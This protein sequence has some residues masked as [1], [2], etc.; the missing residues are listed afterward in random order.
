MEC[1]RPGF[2]E[3]MF[4]EDCR[5]CLCRKFSYF[6]EIMAHAG[7]WWFVA[8]WDFFHFHSCSVSVREMALW[9]TCHTQRRPVTPVE[10]CWLRNPLLVL[11]VEVLLF[12][13]RGHHFRWTVWTRK[14]L[15]LR[16][17]GARMS[18]M[19]PWFWAS[20]RK[21]LFSLMHLGGCSRHAN[22]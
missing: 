19:V 12:P 22:A 20:L 1:K 3:S 14:D 21:P 9:L 16:Q 13:R 7:C 15:P 6:D 10:L 5:R 2:E 11:A 4:L 17:N 18:A 8:F